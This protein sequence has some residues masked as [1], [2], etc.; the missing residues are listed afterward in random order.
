MIGP[1]L[2][3][4]FWETTL[5]CNLRCAHCRATATP[6]RAPD[7]LSTAEAFALVEDIVSFASPILVLSGGEPL[8]RPD[9]LDIA[10]FASDAGLRVALAT[11]GTLIDP[12]IAA[13]IAGAGIRRVSIS[14]DGVQA[15]THDT[16]RGVSGAFE[17]AM[18]GSRLLRANDVELQINTTVTRHNVEELEAILDLTERQGAKA[19][20]FFLL[21]PVGCGSGDHGRAAD[22]GARL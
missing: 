3:L 15:S 20:H 7:E 4:V 5:G 9:I 22:H 21:V 10:R 16:F 18:E 17:A 14:L 13:D 1:D 11:N 2:R 6:G 12:E 8:Y 19:L